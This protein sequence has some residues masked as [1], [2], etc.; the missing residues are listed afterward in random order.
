MSGAAV[1][2]LD[3][4]STFIVDCLH[5]TAPT[6]DDGYPLIRTPNIGKGRLDLDAVHRVSP[7]TYE[8]WTQRAVPEAGDLIFAREATAGNVAIVLEGQQVCLGQRTVHI[9]PNREM[10]DP[11]FLCYFLLAPQQQGLLMAA[12]TGATAKH[13]NMKDIRRLPLARMPELPLQKRIGTMLADYDDLIA[14]NRRRI[15]LLEDSVRLLFD[16]WFVRG[17]ACAAPAAGQ[18]PRLFTLGDLC[19]DLRQSVLPEE[20]DPSTPYIGL[21]HMPR[22]S[23][24]LSDWGAASDVSSSKLCYSS[25]DVV[26]GKIRPYF[27]KVGLALTDGVCSSDAIV[28]RAKAPQWRAL[29]LALVSSDEFVAATSQAMKEGSKMPRADWKQMKAHQISVPSQRVL[30]AFNAVVDPIL[31]QIKILA[32]QARALRTARDL[33]LPRLMSGELSV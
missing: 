1:P 31:G 7:A 32:L 28:M 15:Q 33:L 20:L 22:R 23:I 25:G 26:F 14:N 17:E 18:E 30:E 2:T 8:T 16:E 13:I 21:E 24:T 9:R 5:A 4:V 12:E 27:H 29:L 3:G 11:N 6:E 19:E 10:V